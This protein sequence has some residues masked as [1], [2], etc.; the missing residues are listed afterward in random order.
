MSAKQAATT[1]AL[2]AGLVPNVLAFNDA[3][4]PPELQIR[5]NRFDA[6]QLGRMGG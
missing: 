4:C 6:S 3:V 1:I 5:E 2:E